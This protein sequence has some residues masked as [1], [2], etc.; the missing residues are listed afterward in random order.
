M[1]TLDNKQELEALLP[2]YL[3][4]SLDESEKVRVER[5]LAED[6]DLRQE[7]AFIE[8]MQQQIQ[9]LPEQSPGEFGLKR[10]QRSLKQQQAQHQHQIG[11]AEKQLTPAKKGWQFLAIAASLILVLQTVTVVQKQDDY[12]AAG[13]NNVVQKHADT[14]SVTFTGN[15]TEQ[16]IRQLLLAHNI[17][18]IDGP[19]AIG[20]Y[21]LAITAD[22]HTTMQALQ[23]RSDLIESIQQD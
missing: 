15:A 17:V 10:L 9:Q 4:G 16:Q 22:P 7:L 14:V 12:Q 8:I 3:N 21:R 20:L 19:S 11:H 5:A 1:T 13:G 23:A 18:I 6:E 2:F